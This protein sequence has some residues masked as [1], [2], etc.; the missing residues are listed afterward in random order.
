MTERRSHGHHHGHDRGTA[1]DHGHTHGVVDPMITASDRGIW[2]IK[3]SFIGLAGTA[4]IQFVVA[5]LSG[6]IGLLA[7][8]IHNIGDAAT[9]VPLG[10]AFLLS[11][12]KPSKRFTFGY[13]RVED[14]A[15]MAVVLTILISA[16][17]AGYETIDRFSAPSRR[18]ASMGSYRGIDHRFCR[19]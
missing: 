16:L 12:W 8:T 18:V 2:A 5:M 11:R 3:W 14:L 13:G 7:D 1:H 15:G 9:A 6:S 4:A 19:Q 17:V 10:I